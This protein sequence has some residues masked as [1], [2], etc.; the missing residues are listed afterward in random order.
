M[1][2]DKKLPQAE[3]HCEQPYRGRLRITL[4]RDSAVTVRIPEFTTAAEMT[5]RVNGVELPNTAKS[6]GGQPPL[7]Q[8]DREF[9]PARRFGNYLELGKLRDGDHIEIAYPL[10]IR[11]EDVVVGNPGFRQWR[12]RVTWKGDTVVRM[13]PVENDV[14]TGYSDFDKAKVE[15]FYSRSGPGLLYQRSQMLEDLQPAEPEL[16]SDDGALDFW[17]IK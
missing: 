3:I 5:V 4:K 9:E 8:G 13:E 14:E 1:H 2:I 10:P 17:K 12:Y 15:V 16:C 11:S 6:T 7:R